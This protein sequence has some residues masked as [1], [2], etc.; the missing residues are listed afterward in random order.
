MLPASI[1]IGVNLQ[2]EVEDTVS[3]PAEY[4]VLSKHWNGYGVFSGPIRHT[5]LPPSHSDSVPSD[6]AGLRLVATPTSLR[7]SRSPTP[8]TSYFSDSLKAI[9]VKLHTAI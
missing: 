5:I 1:C 3:I 4:L 2:I 9:L 7:V 8:P 6:R